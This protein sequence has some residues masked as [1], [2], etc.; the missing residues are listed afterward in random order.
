[1]FAVVTGGVGGAK[2]APVGD[3][4][5]ID[6]DRA[7][8]DVAGVGHRAGS[9]QYQVA[10]D[11]G[12]VPVVHAAGLDI[13]NGITRR[14]AGIDDSLVDQAASTEQQCSGALQGAAVGEGA[15]HAH[16]QHPVA[17]QH[18]AGAMGEV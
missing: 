8:D 10:S 13:D 11:A 5:G 17:L 7:A 12:P 9:D 16:V 1:A 4:A 14:V 15:A 18:L 3:R 6:Q 2:V